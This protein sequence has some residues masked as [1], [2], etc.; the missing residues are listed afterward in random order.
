MPVSVFKHISVTFIFVM[1]FTLPARSQGAVRPPSLTLEQALEQAQA[2]YALGISQSQIQVQR[3]LLEQA[4]RG[5]NPEL[6]VGVEEFPSLTGRS[7]EFN[8]IWQQAWAISGRLDRHKSLA[9][10]EL[11]L[12]RTDLVLKA[13]QLRRDVSQLFY[14]VLMWQNYLAALESLVH[15]IQSGQE[16]LKKRF[17]AGELLLT[18]L[19]RAQLQQENIHLS[20]ESASLSWQRARSQLALLLNQQGHQLPPLSGAFILDD[21]SPEQSPIA[22]EV[23]AKHPEMRQAKQK[24]HRHELNALLQESLA[25]PDLTSRLGA[26]YMPYE[27]NLGSVVNLSWPIPLVNANQGNQAAVREHIKQARLNQD[28]TYAR[29][30][31]HLEQVQLSYLQSQGLIQRYQKHILP[32][33]EQNMRL[34]QI[35]YHAGKLSYLEVLDTQR[36]RLELKLKYIQVWGQYWQAATELNYLLS[37]PSE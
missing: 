1:S 10:Q 31:N 11:Q 34:T 13:R 4:Q 37:E 5:P 19:N 33:T 26:R 27:N 12:A 18:E 22:P 3:A 29:L 25:W 32:I 28:A 16:L 9:E 2:Y 17:Q 20:R 35:A 30:K 23:L 36:S 14:Q 8:L 24:I 7:G 15:N 6:R 21:V